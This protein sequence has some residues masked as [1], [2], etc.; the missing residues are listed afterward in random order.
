[1]ITK[2]ISRRRKAILR[3]LGAVLLFFAAVLTAVLSILEV[4]RHYPGFGGPPGLIRAA[5]SAGPWYYG[6]FAISVAALVLAYLA[7]GA[8]RRMLAASADEVLSAD[9]RPPIVYLRPDTDANLTN[10]DN[11]FSELTYE[12]EIARAF[13]GIGPFIT[14]ARPAESIPPG[15]RGT[16]VS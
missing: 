14:V 16:G 7:F 1:M 11:Q 9:S 5:V 6:L 3:F 8:G 2:D 12:E 10:P 4:V 15:R 13:R